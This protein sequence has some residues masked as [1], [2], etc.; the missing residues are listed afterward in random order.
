[1]GPPPSPIRRKFDAAIGGADR[2]EHQQKKLKMST[3]ITSN[4]AVT[5]PKHDHASARPSTDAVEEA[6]RED[7]I[8]TENV[9]FAQVST[10]GTKYSNHTRDTRQQEYLSSYIGPKLQ[11]PF[12]PLPRS[13]SVSKETR[14]LTPTSPLATS[15]RPGTE[16]PIFASPGGAAPVSSTDTSS[17]I[18]PTSPETKTMSISATQQAA[19]HQA[20]STEQRLVLV[21]EKAD[22]SFDDENPLHSKHLRNSNVNEFF[23]F[24]SEMSNMPLE[25]L[26]SLTFTFMFALG[27]ERVV[28]KGDETEWSKLKK[29]ARFLFTLY[30]T[31]SDEEE[32]QLVVE[33]G[34]K[35]NIVKAE[36][37]MW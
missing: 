9:N 21:L 29:K 8:T 13:Q 11:P 18:P 2:N 17:R 10:C 5:T 4:Q 19:N 35:K 33:I 25:S 14:P 34:D 28:H 32:F 36:D 23:S 27:N 3:V 15:I 12:Q 37:A 7:P 22:G 20:L 24:V 1:M 30:R 6:L 16:N 31:R 26:D